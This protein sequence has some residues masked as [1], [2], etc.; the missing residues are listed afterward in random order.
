MHLY[1]G[2]RDTRPG[3]AVAW[4]PDASLARDGQVGREFVWAALDCPGY[5]ACRDDGGSMLLGQMT[6]RVDELPLLGGSYVVSA[7]PISRS[8]RKFESGT[9]LH[10]AD[11]RV[12]A[13]AHQVWIERKSDD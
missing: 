5:F 11:G 10:A 13:V 4:T 9:A 2:P 1:A 3:V 6:A 8:G 7:W 12:L